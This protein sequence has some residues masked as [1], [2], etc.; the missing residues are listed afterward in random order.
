M[1]ATPARSIFD[2]LEY[3]GFLPV[4]RYRKSAGTGNE[5]LTR[6][7]SRRPAELHA[8]ELNETAVSRS[9]RS[10]LSAED[11]V[12]GEILRFTTLL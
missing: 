3:S 4:C 10:H 6:D 5:R 7:A 12:A 8:A 1:G 2:K 11:G 9:A